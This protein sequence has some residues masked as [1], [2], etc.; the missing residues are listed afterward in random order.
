MYGERSVRNRLDFVHLTVKE[1]KA[2]DNLGSVETSSWLAKVFALKYFRIKKV[3]LMCIQ[4][5]KLGQLC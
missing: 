2:K 1:E 4:I 3:S 5:A